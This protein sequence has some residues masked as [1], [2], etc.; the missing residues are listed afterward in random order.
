MRLSDFVA[1]VSSANGNDGQLGEDDGS[2]NGGRH[3]EQS[4]SQGSKR[5]ADKKLTL[6]SSPVESGICLGLHGNAHGVSRG[7]K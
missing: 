1:P 7:R 5:N 2:S 6:H 3:L 4:M